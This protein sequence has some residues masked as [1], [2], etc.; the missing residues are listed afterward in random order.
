MPQRGIIMKDFSIRHLKAGRKHQ[1]RRPID[2]AKLKIEVTTTIHSEMPRAD[3]FEIKPGIYPARMN[4]HG[5]VIAQVQ[6]SWAAHTM[7]IGIKPGEFTFV[8]P[9]LDGETTTIIDRDEIARSRWRIT[10]TT[11]SRIYVK[12]AVERKGD[13]ALYVADA[14]LVAGGKRWRWP[15]SKK[16]SALYMPHEFTRF[17]IEPSFVRVER[18]CYINEGDAIA[19]GYDST[20]EFVKAYEA[21]HGVETF[22]QNPWV[23]CIE[24]RLHGVA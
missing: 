13:R 15:K 6:P 14:S 22:D 17:E 18:L 4:Q 12:E 2:E 16:L 3:A 23:W 10:P 5:A 1:T 11:R 9:Y 7:D 24:F 20:V 8:C 21:I 19:E